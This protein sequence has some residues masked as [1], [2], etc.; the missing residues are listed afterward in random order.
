MPYAAQAEKAVVSVILQF[1]EMLAEAVGI[2]PEHFHQPGPRLT[3]EA[4]TAIH[5]EGRPVELIQ[6]NQHMI[7][8]GMLDAAGGLSEVSGLQAYQPTPTHFAAH[9]ALLHDKFAR[10]CGVEL[11]R[12]LE[13]AAIEETDGDGFADIAAKIG[14]LP[15]MAKSGKACNPFPTTRA[16]EMEGT[17]DPLDFVEGLLTDGGASVIYGPSNCG[18][19][20][21]ALDLAACVAAGRPFRGE[22]EVDRGAVVYV[23]LEGTHGARNRIEALKRSGRLPEDTPLFLCFAPVSLLEPG[24]AGRL[25][26]TVAEVAA[27]ATI[28]CKLVILDTLAR[29]MAGGDE[30]SGADMGAAVKAIDA[31]RAATGAHVCVIHHCGKDEARGARGHSPLRAAVD[32]EIEIYRP[33]GQNVSTVRVA[34]QRD[35]PVGE[36]MPFTLESVTLGTDRRKK[37]ITSCVVRHEDPFMAATR[38]TAGRK[39]DVAPV[40]LLELLPQPSTAAWAKVA[41]SELGVGK[42]AFYRAK[43][44]LRKE[45]LART[46]QDGRWESL[47]PL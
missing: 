1:P 45:G 8:R 12:K 38:G 28:P 29:A 19:S 7:D 16:G 43:D 20:F 21:W 47:K 36:P 11:A 4:I 30:N 44:F 3:F 23:A 5:A 42:S 17:T 46:S 24:H 18:K 39:P 37:P 26:E 25:A 35:L 32:T 31:V 34:K 22:M 13:T 6:L 14:E 10:R 33:E 9:L 2:T 40:R 15:A 27:Q 41:N